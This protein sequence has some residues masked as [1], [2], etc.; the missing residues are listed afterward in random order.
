MTVSKLSK[1]SILSPNGYFPRAYKITRVTIHHMAVCW[2]AEQ[3][4]TSFSYPSRQASSNYGIGNDGKIMC[5]VEEENAAWTSSSYDN[6]NRA[7]TI[8]VSNSPEGAVNG[9]WAISDAA[10][11]SLIALC[12]DICDRYGIIPTYTGDT[13]ATFTEHRMFWATGCPGDWIHARLANGQIIRDVIA[14]MKENTKKE[15]KE[16][17][18]LTTKE[19]EKIALKVWSYRNAKLEKSDAYA[20]LRQCRD[21]L[22]RIEKQLTAI[23]KKL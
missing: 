16:V 10:Y 22:G 14:K 13:N 19:I 2:S 12:A 15:A 20:I 4:G 18:A 3:C 21:S 17:M 6:D 9:T 8:E 11:K 1:G 7:I 5:Y 23:N